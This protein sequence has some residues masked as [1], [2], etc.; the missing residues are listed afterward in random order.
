MVRALPK[1][2]LKSSYPSRIGHVI[3]SPAVPWHC[4]DNADGQNMAL[5][6]CSVPTTRSPWGLGLL[7]TGVFMMSQ[8]NVV[9]ALN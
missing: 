7:M 3:K 5:K 4:A 2:L 8:S 1:A 9:S 6:P